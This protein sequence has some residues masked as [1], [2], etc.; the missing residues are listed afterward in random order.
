MVKLVAI[1]CGTKH[2]IPPY[3][4]QDLTTTDFRQCPADD[5]GEWPKKSDSIHMLHD[6][7]LTEKSLKLI[8]TI[9]EGLKRSLEVLEIRLAEKLHHERP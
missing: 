9:T 5:I 4:A 7:S 1:S 3:V 8:W 2:F 6:T